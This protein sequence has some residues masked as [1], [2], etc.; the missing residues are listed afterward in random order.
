MEQPNNAGFLPLSEVQELMRHKADHDMKD[1]F[2]AHAQVEQFLASSRFVYSQLHPDKVVEAVRV[3]S[4]NIC[5]F[6][7]HLRSSLHTVL[8]S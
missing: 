3:T 5:I 6:P 8:R 7:I 1:L 4:V 2:A